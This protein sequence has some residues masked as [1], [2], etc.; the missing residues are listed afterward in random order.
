MSALPLGLSIGKS[1][2]QSRVVLSHRQRGLWGCP[3]AAAA[4][5]ARGAG[6]MCCPEPAGSDMPSWDTRSQL[7]PRSGALPRATAEPSRQ[8]GDGGR[9]KREDEGTPGVNI[10]MQESFYCRGRA[11]GAGHESRAV[12][13]GLPWAGPGHSRASRSSSPGR[14]SR[15]GAAGAPRGCSARAGTRQSWFP[16]WHEAPEVRSPAVPKGFWS[17]ERRVGMCRGF[18]WSSSGS[19]AALGL[20]LSRASSCH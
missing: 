7:C 15:S 12:A 8:P 19:E 1:F 18:S 16:R 5:R 20:A 10:A 17:A 2:C 9:G 6:G 14:V 3:A 11:G 13:K 4:G